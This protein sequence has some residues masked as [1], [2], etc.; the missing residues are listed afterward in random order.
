M[1]IVNIG[2]ITLEKNFNNT[3]LYNT[4]W[5]LLYDCKVLK[6]SLLC[7]KTNRVYKEFDIDLTDL[8]RS[9]GDYVM[10]LNK[11][12]LENLKDNISSLDGEFTVIGSNILINSESLYCRA[13]DDI[14]FKCIF[15]SESNSFKLI[16]SSVALANYYR[17]TCTNINTIL[18]NT[19]YTSSDKNLFNIEFEQTEDTVLPD[20]FKIVTSTGDIVQRRKILYSKEGLGIIPSNISIDDL[21]ITEDGSIKTLEW[22]DVMHYVHNKFKT[23]PKEL[24]SRKYR[25][26]DECAQFYNYIK[27][28]SQTHNEGKYVTPKVFDFMLNINIDSVAILS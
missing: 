20:Y 5:R 9:C 18:N 14:W 2:K 12:I 19:S 16:Q 1:K 26:I 10:D 25:L 15:N 11:F 3:T 21:V 28:I 27:G 22:D 8:E 23:T 24:S 6:I 13:L 4:V 17:A 7:T